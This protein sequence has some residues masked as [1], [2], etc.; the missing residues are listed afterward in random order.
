MPACFRATEG[1]AELQKE[2]R[3]WSEEDDHVGEVGL[4]GGPA[5]KEQL[6]LCFVCGG[7]SR[8]RLRCGP[9]GSLTPMCGGC[10]AESHYACR[11]NQ[12]EKGPERIP[13]SEGET[14]VEVLE[15][16]EKE[17]VISS[18][19]SED[20]DEDEVLEWQIPEEDSSAGDG[21]G[22]PGEADKKRSSD[23][24]LALGPSGERRLTRGARRGMRC[25]HVARNL[26]LGVRV[27]M[28]LLLFAVIYVGLHGAQ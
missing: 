26:V 19:G 10:F 27:L 28:G 11:Y 13:D 22:R 23:P 12:G 24:E 2:A 16:G 1:V 20:E 25:K 18:S 5:P 9:C 3:V 4:E 8:H 6:Y 14:D 15:W 21:P 7:Y 17:E